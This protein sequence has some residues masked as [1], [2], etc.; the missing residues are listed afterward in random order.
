[1]NVDKFGHHL[2]KVKR[3]RKDYVI[4]DCALCNTKG[5]ELDANHKIIKNLKLPV[6]LNDSATKEYVDTLFDSCLQK[7]K[8]LELRLAEVIRKTDTVIKTKKDKK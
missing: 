2:N 3:F 8:S 7:I 5:G 6:D 1:M 4:I